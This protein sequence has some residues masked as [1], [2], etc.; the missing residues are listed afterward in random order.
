[1]MI[2]DIVH[3]ETNATSLPTR[4]EAYKHGEAYCD[5][6]GIKAHF[7][8]LRNADRTGFVIS[9]T[10]TAPLRMAGFL[11]VRTDA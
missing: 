6:P 1:M 7:A 9:V 4:S 5:R 11:A 10:Q 3:S 2:Y 8:T